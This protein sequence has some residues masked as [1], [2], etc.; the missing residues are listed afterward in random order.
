MI[1][2][3]RSDLL[4]QVKNGQ[5]SVEE[6]ERFL[7]RQPF[8]EMGFAKLDT[9]RKLR[10]GVAEVVFCSG[11]KDEYLL[12]IYKRLYEVHGEVLGTRAD[13]HQ[14]ELLHDIFPQVTYDEASRILKIEK[15]NKEDVGRVA[16]S[17]GSGSDG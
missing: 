6:A 13:I 5:L 7:K 12:E 1:R 3:E 4:E 14:Y 8:E 2:M 16:S 15:E 11:K 10:Q 9:H 17:G